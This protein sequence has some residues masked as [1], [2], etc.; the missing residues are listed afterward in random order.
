ME[1]FRF[2]F[3]F[4]VEFKFGLKLASF[5]G[6]L[7][8]TLLFILL[9]GAFSVASI[10]NLT[11][12]FKTFK[13]KLI[14]SYKTLHIIVFCKKLNL[15]KNLNKSVKVLMTDNFSA[16]VTTIP[17][18]N[19]AQSFVLPTLYKLGAYD[20]INVWII[21]FDGSVLHTYWGTVENL[22][23]GSL[24]SSTRVVD[25][26]SS[27]RNLYEQALLDARA[28]WKTKC[29]KDGYSDKTID[30]N[31]LSMPAM[32]AHT[33]NPTGKQ[34]RF[35]AFTSRKY[36]GCRLRANEI[37]NDQI[38]MCSRGTQVI[39]HF[40][41]IRNNL[42]I[43]FPYIRNVLTRVFPDKHPLF[44]SDGE[45]YT[46]EI[47]VDEANGIARLG[48]GSPASTKE[49]LFTYYIFDL[50]IDGKY[51][52]D[53]RLQI[54]FQGY[55]EC[56]REK[57]LSGIVIVEQDLV[58]SNAEIL[59]KHDQYVAEGYEGV[60]IRMFGGQTEKEREQSYYKDRRCNAILK[61]K[62]FFDDEGVIIG[63][64]ED[65]ENSVIWRIKAKN[66]AIFDCRPRGR[67]E[68][69][70]R[71]YNE[72]ATNSANFIG[73]G[74]TYR[75]QSL[76]SNGVP[77]FATGIGIVSDRVV[78]GAY[79]TNSEIENSATNKITEIG[80]IVGASAGQSHENSP[81]VWLIRTIKGDVIR[82]VPNENE[83][84]KKS[85][86]DQW[87]KTNGSVFLDKKY[88]FTYTGRGPN[89]EYKNILGDKMLET[90][91]GN[92]IGATANGNVLAWT[93]AG[94]ITVNERNTNTG[95]HYFNEWMKDNGAS[96]VGKKLEY[97]IDNGIA[98]SIGFVI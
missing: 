77:Q 44:R 53:E 58:R 17:S 14:R 64:S 80:N 3:K 32:L 66:G 74:F 71:L 43:L 1:R 84:T 50:I 8:K 55:N 87:M 38:F 48:I 34:V 90:Q 6:I 83:E 92:I 28:S 65:K 69:R 23:N 21:S 57:K 96:F 82:I 36:E 27:G 2:G 35:P 46:P 10:L 7:A 72:Y 68:E 59:A 60:I 75:Y 85:Y 76:N 9:E 4:C 86:F 18:A 24:Q 54:L 73:R 25:L 22:A 47:S 62:N 91:I 78:P 19:V 89:G 49:H 16:A 26:N 40:D 15:L 33:F 29:D 61:Y 42:K 52:Y 93:I 94:P 98:Y 97:E 13:V 37:D 41:N 45:L 39:N 11:L 95:I 5:E 81:I 67:L 56:V 63:A 70:R 79:V 20:K 30:K 12:K 31:I 88:R 51:T